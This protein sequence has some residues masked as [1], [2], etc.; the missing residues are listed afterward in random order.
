MR[1]KTAPSANGRKVEAKPAPPTVITII[2]PNA[3]LDAS[4]V[5]AL[6]GLRKSSLRREIREKR[7][8]VAKRCGR[9]FFLGRWILEWIE[10]GELAK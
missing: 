9:H 6:L 1:V 7:L 5:Q 8:R 4:H 3:V 10:G 2:D